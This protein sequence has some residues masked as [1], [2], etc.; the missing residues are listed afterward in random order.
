MSTAGIY[1]GSVM[2][3]RVRPRRH[4]LR[5]RVFSLLLDVDAAEP[6]RLRLF[7]RNRKALVSFHDRDHG[8]GSDNL[9]AWVRLRLVEAGLDVADVRIEALCYPRIFGYVFNPLTVFFCWRA[10]GMLVAML[11]EVGNTLGEKHTYV[12][13]AAPDAVDPASG[14]IRQRCDKVFYVSPFIAM[15]CVYEFRIEPPGEQVRISIVEKDESGAFLTAIF[16]GDRKPLDD[17]SLAM[18]L[19]SHP[20][21]TLKVT[22]GIYWEALRLLLKRMPVHRHTRAASRIS[23]SIVS[24]HPTGSDTH[25]HL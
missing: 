24:S 18:A 20:L 5:Y 10:D 19:M 11:Y 22:L 25:E 17:R 6:S 1:A 14:R 8:D 15:D 16:S 3:T 21:M 23:Y 2:H 4:H 7:G 13:P 12:I 9:G